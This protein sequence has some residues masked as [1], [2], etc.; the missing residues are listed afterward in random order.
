[1]ARSGPRSEATTYEL[2]KIDGSFRR[3]D[4]APRGLKTGTFPSTLQLMRRSRGRDDILP[5]HTISGNDIVGG[6]QISNTRLT[7]IYYV[8]HACA[9]P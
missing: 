6:R 7:L 1:M 5:M 4:M 3:S 8:K 9:C 2:V